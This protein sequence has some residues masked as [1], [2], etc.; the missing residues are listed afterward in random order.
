[1]KLNAK[2]IRNRAAIA[3]ELARACKL[4]PNECDINRWDGTAGYCKLNGQTLIAS[5]FPHHGEEPPIRGHGGSGTLF[6]AGCNLLCDF[7]Q[8]YSI[9]H[10]IEGTAVSAEETA[11]IMLRL[12]SQGCENINFV[13]PSHVI[14]HILEALAI[15]TERGLALPIVYN[16][17]GYD[18]VDALRLLDGIVDIYMPDFKF[19]SP[20]TAQKLT[21]AEDYPEMAQAA[22]KEM[23]RQ[24]GDLITNDRGVALRGL[25]IRHLVLPNGLA[26]TFEVMRFLHDEVSPGIH[27]NI[28][29][30]YHPCYKAHEIPEINRAVTQAEVQEALQ[31]ARQAGI[32]FFVE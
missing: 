22:V 32:R 7:C 25:L 3:K 14:H 30:Q 26:D 13:S 8:N 6:F 9:S 10:K 31:A 23:H 2:E 4:C 11:G 12:Q 16:S 17:G 18:S 27:V 24:V 21:G 29:G 15:A 19:W 28:M 5:A 1:M 20:E